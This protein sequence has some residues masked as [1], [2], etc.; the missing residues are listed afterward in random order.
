[1]VA[2]LLM[3]V[4]LAI[5]QLGLTLYVRNALVAAASEGARLAA[6]ADASPADGVSRTRSLITASVGESYARHV[7][8]ARV[9]EPAGVRVV[10]VTVQAPFPVVGPL[11]PS[12]ALTI[13]G[14][15][16]AE[17]QVAGTTP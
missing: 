17:D 9:T 12:G 11:G 8:A 4:A 2:A 3:F 6:R 1:M 5:L 10:E 14:R 16:F 7:S 13:T 15:A